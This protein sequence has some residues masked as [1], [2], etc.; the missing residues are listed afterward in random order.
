MADSNLI[1]YSVMEVERLADR[2]Y[3]R[4]CSELRTESPDFARDL[5]LGSRVIRV[6]ALKFMPNED[7]KIDGD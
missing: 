1:T 6:L 3:S 7:I 2:L 4:G 5:R